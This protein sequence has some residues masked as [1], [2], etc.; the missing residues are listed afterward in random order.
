M[1]QERR[2]KMIKQLLN[3]SH[4]S[5]RRQTT[6]ARNL[7]KM[8]GRMIYLKPQIRRASLHMKNLYKTLSKAINNN[9]DWNS[10]LELQPKLLKEWQWWIKE[11][12]INY[13]TPFQQIPTQAVL[14]TDASK[15]GWGSTLTINS[16]NKMLTCAGKWS[17]KW[18]LTSSNQ[19]ELAAVHCAIRRFA[20]KLKKEKIRSLHL[21]TDNTTTSFN[22]NRQNSSRSLA[23][24]TDRTLLLLE[25]MQI[26]IQATYL[27]GEQNITADALSRLNGAGDYHLESKIFIQ[28]INQAKFPATIDLFANKENK[29]LK[30]YCTT[31]IDK[32]AVARDAFSISWKNEYPII[33]PPIPVIGRCLEIIKQDKISAL[34]ILPKWTSQYWWPILMQMASQI[35]SLGNSG[36]VLKNGPIANRKGWA[37]PPGE[38]IA[39]QIQQDKEVQMEKDFTDKHQYHVEQPTKQQKIKQNNYKEVGEDINK[40][41]D[42]SPSTQKTQE[43]NAQELKDLKQPQILILNFIEWQREQEASSACIINSK[44]ALSTLLIAIGHQQGQIYNNTTANAVKIDR[45]NTAKK[46]KDQETYNV[47]QILNYIRQRVESDQILSELEIQ[48]ITLTIIMIVTTRRMSEIQRCQLNQSET[49]SDIIKLESDIYKIGGAPIQLTLKRAKDSRVCP[50]TWFKKW[51]QYQQQRSVDGKYLWWNFQKQTTASADYCSRQAKQI[52]AAAGEKRKFRI[53]ELRSASITKAIDSGIPMQAINSWS[54]HSD[55]NKT[56]Q[57]YYFRANSDQIIDAVLAPKQV[58]QFFQLPVLKQKRG[59]FERAVGLQYNQLAG[60]TC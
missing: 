33:H 16:N 50:V 38:I 57:R 17:K 22:I 46:I 49:T 37:L 54:V 20:K 40:D 48:A 9:K 27:P 1:P 11:V 23:N 3:W 30:R 59:S 28:L 13:P 52:I 42:M 55:A 10:M 6:S 31:Q 34:M 2:K 26:Q 35:Y 7:S 39:V 58:Y 4:K 5:M 44:A 60:Y 45:R 24:L 15:R 36:Q 56:L 29:L 14:T 51:W 32:E 12:K 21:Q 53:T 18:K 8:L 47:D 43:I 25:Q 41:W 19:R